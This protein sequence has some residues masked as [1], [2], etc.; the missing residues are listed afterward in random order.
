[1]YLYRKKA[2]MPGVARE[3][4][5]TLMEIFFKIEKKSNLTMS[6]PWVP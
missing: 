6:L 5:K 1:M 3:I 4:L 2:E